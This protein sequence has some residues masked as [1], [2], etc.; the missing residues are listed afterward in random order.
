MSK[1]NA[2]E[3]DYILTYYQRIVDGTETVGRW[4]R[5]WYALV[6]T[7]M[8]E[9]RFCFDRKKAAK[10]IRFCENFCRHH[11]GPLAPGLIRLELWQKA[12]G[13][14]SSAR[15]SWRSGGRTARRCWPPP[16]PST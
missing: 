11:E 5:D 14:G 3:Q 1:K 9:K 4:I 6:V 10:A 15:C 2:G 8:Q 16:S 12:M 7:G 13:T